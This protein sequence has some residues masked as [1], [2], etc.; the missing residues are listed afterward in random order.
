MGT[1]VGGLCLCLTL[2]LDRGLACLGITKGEE[3][4]GSV[5]GCLEEVLGEGCIRTRKE[6]QSAA[7]SINYTIRLQSGKT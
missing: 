5:G 4:M 3:L 1:R 6:A 2:D 7:T